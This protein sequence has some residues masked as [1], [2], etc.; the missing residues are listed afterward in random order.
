MHLVKKQRTDEDDCVTSVLPHDILKE[1]APFL[2]NCEILN[3]AQCSKGLLCAVSTIVSTAYFTSPCPGEGTDRKEHR[4]EQTKRRHLVG[5]LSRAVGIRHVVLRGNAASQFRRACARGL[6]KRVRS[7]K[8]TVG[9]RGC[10]DWT[11]RRAKDLV[12]ACEHLSLQRV[13]LT[14]Y[15]KNTDIFQLLIRLADT[16][17]IEH[18]EILYHVYQGYYSTKEFDAAVAVLSGRPQIRTIVLKGFNEIVPR[19]LSACTA[20]EDLSTGVCDGNHV[21]AYL[22]NHGQRLRC[23]NI[24]PMRNTAAIVDCLQQNSAP[25]L[26]ELSLFFDDHVSSKHIAR[27]V[28]GRKL[29]SLQL[30]GRM[31]L[32]SVAIRAALGMETLR[33]LSVGNIYADDFLS[34][35]CDAIRAPLCTLT[36][37]MIPVKHRCKQLIKHILSSRVGQSFQHIRLSIDLTTCI[38]VREVIFAPTLEHLFYSMKEMRD[39]VRSVDL[40]RVMGKEYKLV[41]EYTH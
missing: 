1:I 25:N 41:V 20:L 38:R 15:S 23:L 18:V 34:I 19:V 9:Q 17:T 28:L 40:T 7:I 29:E 2:R 33:S 13:S 35:P 39:R 26:R 14:F 16:P 22:P 37:D 3:V 4:K 32:T 24:I 10:C 30:Y 27:M 8:L 31:Q 6:C 12:A 5:L 11:V 21:A 36:M